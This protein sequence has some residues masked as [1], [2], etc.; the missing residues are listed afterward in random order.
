M[1]VN[2]FRAFDKATGEMRWEYDLPGFANANPSS[3]QEEG[4]QY[5]VL[6]VGGNSG[7]TAG[8][9]IAFALPE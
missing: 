1:R 7:N 9:V 5:I 8:S 6:S 4:K 3:Y 2:K